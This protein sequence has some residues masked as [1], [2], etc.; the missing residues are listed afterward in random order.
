FSDIICGIKNAQMLNLPET[1]AKKNKKGKE[2]GQMS[3]VHHRKWLWLLNI[4]I[5]GDNKRG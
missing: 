4:R 1:M 2:Q 3:V 5:K